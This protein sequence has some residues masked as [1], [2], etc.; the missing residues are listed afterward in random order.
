MD[1]SVWVACSGSVVTS[2]ELSPSV[3]PAPS[4]KAADRG[5]DL[6]EIA[7]RVEFISPNDISLAKF[8]GSGG[9]GEV[10]PLLAHLLLLRSPHP[11]MQPCSVEEPG[12]SVILHEECLHAAA[13]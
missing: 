6:G 4:N 3:A 2:G 11:S 1:L 8:L 12:S 10:Q 7:G 5:F 13:V 9:Y